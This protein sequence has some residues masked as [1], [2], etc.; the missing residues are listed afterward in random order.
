MIGLK[1][2][3]EADKIHFESVDG[4]HLQFSSEW[5]MNLVRE[6]LSEDNPTLNISKNHTLFSR[7]KL[8]NNTNKN[9]DN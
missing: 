3:I 1:Q 4:D 7:I 6:Y 2:L 8:K 5:F 9:Y